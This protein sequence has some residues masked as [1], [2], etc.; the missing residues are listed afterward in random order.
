MVVLLAACGDDGRPLP[1]PAGGDTDQIQP[2]LTAVVDSSAKLWIVAGY[3]DLSQPAS[4]MGVSLRAPDG[5]W[6][7]LPPLAPV[8]QSF[9]PSGDAWLAAAQNGGRAY[10]VSLVETVDHPTTPDEVGD[11]LA[12]AVIDVRSGSPQILSP[13]RI[14]SGLWPSWDEP[15]VAATHP[16]GAVADTVIVAGTPIGPDVQDAVS[17]LVSHNG[18]ESFRQTA[19][20]HAPSYPGHTS[21]APDNTL[22]RPFLQQDPRPGQECHA[23]LAYG[24]YYATALLTTYDPPACAAEPQGCRSIAET[25]TNDCGESWGE[26][27][28]I[29]IDTGQATG[30]DFRGF[31]YAVANDGSRYVMFGDEDAVDAPILLKSAP[32][33][34]AFT[35]VAGGRWDDGAM[36]TIASGPSAA[37][38][39]VRR[40]RPT[41]AASDRVAALWVEEDAATQA[42]TVWMATSDGS[43]GPPVR[44][45]DAGIACDGVTFP[46]DDYMGVVPEGPFGG[47][48]TGFVVAW[49]P[50][51]AC[52]SPTPRRVHF[53][54]V[55]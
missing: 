39:R 20:I 54:T 38:A 12:L 14:D 27:A 53:K 32:A 31:S 46:S 34:G 16:P 40:W 17:V 15:T 45:D 8:G 24:V 43:F 51:E 2:A 9:R 37:G 21:N 28:F 10:Y 25:E 47:A 42:S 7:S 52:G 26:P 35:V 33:G 36:Q 3:T 13:R 23:L 55:R 48:S 11:G 18:G 50:F 49:A 6:T 41:L 5:T 4:S 22:V 29:A 19:V 1:I 30:E 44:V